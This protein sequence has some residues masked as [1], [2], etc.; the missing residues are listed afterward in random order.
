M[1]TVLYM[2]VLLHAV[3]LPAIA[4]PILRLFSFFVFFATRVS[5][6]YSGKTAVIAY[7]V[8]STSFSIKNLLNYWSVPIH[9]YTY[10]LPL[11]C[12]RIRSM[13]THTHL[14]Y[15]NF[16]NTRAIRQFRVCISYIM[17]FNCIY[18]SKGTHP[19]PS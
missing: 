7:K 19:R 14:V 8:F 4:F 3:I 5:L 6:P 10:L 18:T 13:H 9:T 2:Y 11:Y 16:C 1:L 12:S 15:R 17:Y